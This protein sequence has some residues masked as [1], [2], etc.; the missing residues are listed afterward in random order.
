MSQNPGH[1]DPHHDPNAPQ[2]EGGYQAAPS[3]DTHGA[4]GGAPAGAVAKP[5]PVGL[6]EKLMYAGGA[7]SLISGVLA[8]ATPE[9][10]LRA[11]VESQLEAS[12]Q[13]VDP[14]VVDATV[15]GAPIIGLISGIV[16]AAIWFLLGF[17]N[18][19][20]KSWARIVATIL[21]VIN[22]VTTLIGLLGTSMMP[23]SAA[24]GTINTILSLLGAVLAAVI[25]FLLWRKESTAY[26]K[27][28]R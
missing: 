9:D 3:Y 23:G 5:Q 6:A 2:H 25:V 28:T 20:G 17:F 13:P 8:L 7:L 4:H 22:V 16:V 15:S 1:E 24:G 11:A 27:S 14:A 18:G 10:Q 19:K 12:G 21:G 26:F